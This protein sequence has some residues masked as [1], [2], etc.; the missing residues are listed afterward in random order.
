M[1]RLC[2]SSIPAPYYYLAGVFL[3]EGKAHYGN[4][5]CLASPWRSVLQ[6]GAE[7]RIRAVCDSSSRGRV[8]FFG[9][10]PC[11]IMG[12]AEAK[13]VK[14]FDSMWLAFRVSYF[15]KLALYA[16]ARGLNPAEI[17]RGV[18]LDPCI[19]PHCRNL[20]FGCDGLLP[21]EGFRTAAS[22]LL[23]RAAKPFSRNCGVKRYAQGFNRFSCPKAASQKSGGVASCEEGKARQL[24]SELNTGC[25]ENSHIC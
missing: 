13:G 9:G 16:K 21:A 4:L 11:L 7:T 23:R 1:P 5:I 19:D 18:C 12:S 6:Q 24:P 10:I 22:Q 8:G 17:I 3:C 14:L 25:S 15:N 2:R 20:L